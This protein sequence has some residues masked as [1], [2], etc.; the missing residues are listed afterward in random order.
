[1][2]TLKSEHQHYKIE[3]REGKLY[4]NDVSLDLDMSDLGNQHFH[5]IENHKSFEAE[6]LELNKEEK[7]VLI[8]VNSNVYRFDVSDQYDIL[9]KEMGL[10]KLNQH[11]V[12]EL[13][14]PMPGL[15]LQV[16][17]Q[18]GD[19]IK[20]GDNLLVLEAMKME[21]ILKAPADATVKSILI[22][23]GDKVEKNQVLIQFA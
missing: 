10:D 4:L 18:A 7:Y 20:K 23:A 13:K 14:A 5:V 1:M 21:N 11:I 2:Y 22:K 16:M 9:L 19:E 17:V 12:K 6:L 15:V 8:K 3:E